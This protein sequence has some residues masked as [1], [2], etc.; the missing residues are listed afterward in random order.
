VIVALRGEDQWGNPYRVQRDP[1]LT[2]ADPTGT[3]GATHARLDHLGEAVVPTTVTRAGVSFITAGR[4]GSSLG[5]SS[6]LTVRP[7]PADALELDLPRPWVWVDRPVEIGLRAIDRYHNDALV[8]LTADLTSA[9]GVFEP[10]TVEIV[11]GRAAVTVT[12]LRDAVSDSWI[13]VAGDLLGESAELLVA[14]DCGSGG[15]SAPLTLDG[16]PSV[17]A[18]D[19]GSD[20][21]VAASLAS[22]TGSPDRFGFWVEGGSGTLDSS[23]S[24][25]LR[26]SGV[27]AYE[28]IGLAVEGTCATE[29]TARVWIAPDDGTPAGPIPLALDATSLRIGQDTAEL[30]VDAATDC[31]GE[32]A[33]GGRVFLRTDRGSLTGVTASGGGLVVELDETGSASAGLDLTRALGGGAGVVTAW[34]A[35]PAAAGAVAFDAIG[36]KLHPRVISQSPEGYASGSIPSVRVTFTEPIDPGSL[37]LQ[38]FKFFGPSVASVAFVEQPQPHVLDVFP[39]SPIAAA[40]GRWTLQIGDQVTDLAGNGLD[41]ADDG[42]ASTYAA[43]FGAV[44]SSAPTGATC[45]TDRATFRPDGDEGAGIEADRSRISLSGTGVGSWR[46]EVVDPQGLAVRHARVEVSSSGAA[47]FDF[48]GRDNTERVLPDGTYNVVA[49]PRNDDGTAGATCVVAVSIDNR[50]GR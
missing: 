29:G 21:S 12:P 18:C 23:S 25:D 8:D 17:I 47:S 45:S 37:D 50:R 22:A 36:D 39:S 15:P 10:V 48:D 7:A 4:D 27:G 2:L 24:I 43:D 16:G 31:A 13:A 49:R 1:V 30:L 46:I 38:A 6:A 26:F 42:E 9:D 20:V 14:R 19:S 44:S 28:V 5:T 32:P 40:S 41:G 3:L 11:R 34:A 33:A 35:H